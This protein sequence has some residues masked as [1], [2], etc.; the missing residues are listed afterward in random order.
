VTLNRAWKRGD[1][2]RLSL[3]MPVRRV[4]ANDAVAADRGRVALQR[5]PLVYCAEWPD[6]PAGRVRNLM[7]SDTEKLRTEFKPDLLRGVEVIEGRALSLTRDGKG[8][9]TRT[10]QPFTA[11]PY[12]AWANR[13]RGEMQVWIAS[14]ESSARP[15]PYPT[16]ASTSRVR[17]SGGQNPRAI[18]DQ[19]D[20]LSSGDESN[21]FFHWWPKKGTTE[22][23][24]YSLDRP[25]TVSECEVY[26]FDDTGRGECRVPASWRILYR[27]GDRWKPVETSDDYA[28]GLDRYNRVSFKPVTTSALRLEVTLKPDWSAGIQE[29]RVK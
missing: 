20:P 27:D 15:L 13:G 19:A 14:T 18:N 12:Y 25:A 11:I 8:G 29:W 26:W 1:T 5:G 10:E 3:P 16:I 6:N 28:T 7:L 17:T 22:W 9:V 24:E 4:A 21:P 2:V 23:V